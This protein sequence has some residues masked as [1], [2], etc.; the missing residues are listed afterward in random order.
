MHPQDKVD[1]VIPANLQ[2][3]KVLETRRSQLNLQTGTLPCPPVLDNADLS[4]TF[5]GRPELHI[6]IGAHYA[7]CIMRYVPRM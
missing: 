7:L 6:F 3:F 1:Y 4:S 2:L 5:F